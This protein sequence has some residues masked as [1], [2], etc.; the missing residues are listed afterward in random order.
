LF[1]Q[2]FDLESARVTGRAVP[3]AERVGL[4]LSGAASFSVSAAGVLVHKGEVRTQ[5]ELIWVDRSGQL[6]E[7]I[8]TDPTLV[9]GLSLSAD[10]RQ[11]IT[12]RP[13]PRTFQPALWLTTRGREGIVRIG[14]GAESIISPDGRWVVATTPPPVRIRRIELASGRTDWLLEDRIA[15]PTDWSSD[16]RLI[17]IQHAEPGTQFDISVL[18]PETKGIR[19]FLQTSANE[20]QA[21][22]SPDERW[23]SYVSDSS[24]QPEVYLRPFNA[25]GRETQISTGGGTQPHWRRD[26]KELY[27]LSPDTHVMAV[28]IDI[29]NGMPSGSPKRLFPLRVEPRP[30]GMFGVDYLPASNGDRFLVAPFADRQPT[31][32][33]TVVLNWTAALPK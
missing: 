20:G 25:G 6:I 14:E 18:D 12:T 26:G 3:L 15:W 28:E 22:F 7:R 33:M 8:T 10:D 27:F 30:A 21:R 16:G 23:I 29:R 11:L 13:D 32:D 31:N 2:P 19:P 1:A 5:R 24:G 4:S 17:L 9:D